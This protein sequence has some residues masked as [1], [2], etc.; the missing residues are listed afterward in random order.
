M[1][2]AI[3]LTQTGGPNVLKTESITDGATG[4]G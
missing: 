3:R 1:G 4:A 2:I